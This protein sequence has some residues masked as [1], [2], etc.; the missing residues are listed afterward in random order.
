M[1]WVSIGVILA[2]F[3]AFVANQWAWL[4]P[5]LAMVRGWF[6][7]DKK[8]EVVEA[9]HRQ[10]MFAALMTL[11]RTCEACDVCPL[12]VKKVRTILGPYIVGELE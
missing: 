3:T 10:A 11:E 4:A 12:D 2:L 7:R 8:P 5:R 1:D 9:N 6:R